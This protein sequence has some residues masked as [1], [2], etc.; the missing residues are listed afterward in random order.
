VLPRS[1]YASEALLPI[2]FTH[3]DLLKIYVPFVDV[4][5]AVNGYMRTRVGRSHRREL[6]HRIKIAESDPN[7]H[8][9]LISSGVA[10]AEAVGGMFL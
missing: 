9:M 1:F 10:A 6:S 8:N 5:E 7:G 4:T 3:N 2:S